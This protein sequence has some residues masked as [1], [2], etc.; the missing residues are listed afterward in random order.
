ML[1]FFIMPF[2]ELNGTK[3]P[4][5]HGFLGGKSIAF[6]LSEVTP[7][8]SKQCT[9]FLEISEMIFDMIIYTFFLFCS[10]NQT[11]QIKLNKCKLLF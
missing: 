2:D 9:T 8:S 11:N 3:L 10:P 7:Q 4:F 5:F 6:V 1:L